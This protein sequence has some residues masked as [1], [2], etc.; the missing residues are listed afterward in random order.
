MVSKGVQKVNSVCEFLGL[1]ADDDNFRDLLQQ[2]PE[3]AL[4]YLGVLGNNAPVIPDT[5]PI[6]LPPKEE[7]RRVLE[8]FD[9]ALEHT[10]DG[11]ELQGWGA[12]AAWVF[13]FITAKTHGTQE[14]AN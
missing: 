11:M 1:L 9:F 3:L 14:P 8:Q 12:W 10:G 5:K 6:H 13:A 7:V 2:N 4:K